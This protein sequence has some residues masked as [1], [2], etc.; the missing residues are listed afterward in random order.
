M[1]GTQRYPHA[2][3]PG[4]EAEPN[5]EQARSY[6]TPPVVTEAAKAGGV[7]VVGQSLPHLAGA[8]HATGEAEYTDDTKP[9]PGTLFGWLVRAA[10]APAT[11]AH[12]DT[13][14]AAASPGV[15]RVLLAA[16]GS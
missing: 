3:Y 1:C 10:Q 2:S 13:S 16:D 8:R 6:I 5:P 15:V 4:L 7:R 11:L 14:A 9:P 12:V